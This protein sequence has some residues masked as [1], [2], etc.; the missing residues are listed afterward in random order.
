MIVRWAQLAAELRCTPGHV[1]RLA[2]ANG[3]A[4]AY[5]GPNRKRATGLPATE[6][7]RLVEIV[8]PDAGSFSR[9]ERNAVQR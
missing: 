2:R 8:S 5:T 3:C 6:A 4:L 1:R 7:W 9:R